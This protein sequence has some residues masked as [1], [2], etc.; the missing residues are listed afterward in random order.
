M[1]LEV[2]KLYISLLSTFFTLS[3]VSVSQT[4]CR[5][6]EDS[7]PVPP[8]VPPGTTVL[9][10][11]YFA[12]RLVE[13]VNEGISELM[14]VDIGSEAGNGLKN[15]LESLRWRMQE[16]IAATWARGLSALVLSYWNEER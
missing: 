13:D 3:D 12:E 10:A 6:A 5:Q 8:F 1:A 9:A 2:V 16:V 7:I 15:M 4:A 11:C 14:G